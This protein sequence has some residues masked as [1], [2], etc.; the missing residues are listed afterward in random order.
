MPEPCEVVVYV[1]SRRMVI[2]AREYRVALPVSTGTGILVR[3]PARGVVLRFAWK[4][5]AVHG[6]ALAEA[7]RLAAER[8]VPLRVVDLGCCTPIARFVRSRL[9]GPR[10]LPVILVKGACMGEPPQDALRRAQ[11]AVLRATG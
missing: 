9:L 11:R 1:R 7:R 5:E 2:E 3:V 10:P 6:E 8:H 4:L